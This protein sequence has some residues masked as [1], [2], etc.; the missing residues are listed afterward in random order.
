[1][2]SDGLKGSGAARNPGRISVALAKGRE[3]NGVKTQSWKV[4]SHP[5]L[6][7]N[8]SPRSLDLW[9]LSASTPNTQESGQKGEKQQR[10]IVWPQY[11]NMQLND[12]F[13]AHLF[14]MFS[15]LC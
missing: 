4:K 8:F 6:T 1:M 13:G 11:C 9:L 5:V 15:F 2:D 12:V 3:L 14:T 7:N 10:G